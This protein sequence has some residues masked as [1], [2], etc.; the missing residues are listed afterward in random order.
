[1]AS[2]S[3]LQRVMELVI[4]NKEAAARALLHEVVLEK[5]REIHESMRHEDDFDDMDH[6]GG[7]DS[8]RW[9][10]E[11]HRHDDEI[12]S[13]GDE[14]DS[15]ET[16]GQHME[17]TE[18]DD[19]D[20]DVDDMVTID[21]E[22]GEDTEVSD[23]YSD[24]SVSDES[25]LSDRVDDLE[26]T[27]DELRAEFE[28]LSGEEGSEDLDEPQDDED[29]SDMDIDGDDVSSDVDGDDVD[30][31]MDSED[32]SQDEDQMDE[33]WLNEQFA[34][35]EEG[36]M[37]DVVKDS[38]FTGGESDQ[39]VGSGKYARPGVSKKSVVPASQRDRFGAKPVDM[40]R[41][42]K[43]SGYDRETPPTGVYGSTSGVDA[44]MKAAKTSNRR[45][46]A[47]DGMMDHSEGNYGA[48]KQAGSK[49]ETTASDFQTGRSKSPF[50][51]IKMRD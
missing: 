14:V 20:S 4:N 9:G 39:E 40:G 48:K 8:E 19:E 23:D 30:M 34:D 35:L 27:L 21:D 15:E 45:K 32:G 17:G 24:D 46:K 10:K 5:A 47:T 38:I 16:F 13:Y 11:V 25:E 33:D 43:H 2:K 1:M 49:L 28:R 18:F 12:E 36:L 29:M 42:P 50:Q 6:M 22:D 3:K 44:E 37:L 51:D 26:A 31:D 41:G 7:D